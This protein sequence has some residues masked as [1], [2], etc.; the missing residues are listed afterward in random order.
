[1]VERSEE[2]NSSLGS[3]FFT[4]AEKFSSQPALYHKEKS[5]G[6]YVPIYWYEWAQNVKCLAAALKKSFLEK[7][8]RVAIL[9]ENRPEWT[10]VDLA[11][12][13]IG[14]VV[15]PIYPTLTPP[16]ISYILK[17]SETKILFV[18]S[19]EQYFRIRDSVFN[20]VPGIKIV[21]FNENQRKVEGTHS[22][23]EF[24]VSG[25]SYLL[26]NPHALRDEFQKV[27]PDDIATIIYTSG[28]T[29]PPKGVMLTHKNFIA[30]VNAARE[31]INVSSNDIAL[32]FL[33]LSHVFERLAGY[34][35]MVFHGAAIAYAESLQTVP[36][37][38]REVSP[39]ICAAVPRFYEKT[40]AR[41]QEKKA[42]ASPLMRKIM[43]W[44]LA[45]G[46]LHAKQKSTGQSLSWTE[47]FAYHLAKILVLNK[48]QKSLGG[49]LRFFIS[50]GAPLS[51]EIAEFFFSAG[52][53]ILEGYG[54][55]ETSPV[56]S[57]NTE[58]EF[59]FGT[60]GKMLPGIEVK[61]QPDGEIITKSD[62]VMKGYFKNEVATAEVIKDGWFYTGDIGIINKDGFLQITDRKK[63]IIVTSGGK[64][65][66]PQNIENLILSDPAF[67][68]I[69]VLGDKRNYLVALISPNQAAVSK[70]A[71]ELR[72]QKSYLELLADP[73]IYDWYDQKIKTILKDF[74]N[75]EQIKYFA[76]LPS[77]LSQDGGELTP[78]LKVKR[79]I[80]FEKYK[81]LI[82][83]LY[84]KVNPDV[85]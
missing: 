25:E 61:I 55:T 72:I 9:S 83:P 54:L 28:T 29:G 27:L 59:Q 34:Y 23:S 22:L 20:E 1:M 7:G 53:L 63:D 76:F 17:H 21:L 19:E 79:R 6:E 5:F 33:P 80:V 12:L 47:R 31:R 26:N 70:R 84:L 15:V 42:A 50:G 46:N 75:Y 62:C 81:Y 36:E 69:V 32:S 48:I 66:S 51:R 77:E 35:F 73:N 41:I 56:I 37:N 2:L 43:D 58:K 85:R 14:C 38:L 71:D 67:S 18:S 16:E 49:K 4:C 11:A 74:S 68:Q 30:N 52:V 65:I 64:N 10:Y 44:A 45:M 24:I 82:D 40:F 78:T 3:V 8:D 39:T 60:V 57:V 13:S